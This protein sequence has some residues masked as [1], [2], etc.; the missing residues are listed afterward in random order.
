MKH[1]VAKKTRTFSVETVRPGGKATKQEITIPYPD[2][3]LIVDGQG[4]DGGDGG[5]G[6]NGGKGGK[7]GKGSGDIPGGNG[8]DGG[9]A[10]KGAS[11]GNGGKGA[12]ITISTFSEY[13][14]VLMLMEISADGGQGGV[15]GRDGTIGQGGL[16]G[17]SGEG[18]VLGKTI[19]RLEQI[20]LTCSAHEGGGTATVSGGQNVGLSPITLPGKKGKNGKTG[21]KVKGGGARD[22]EKGPAG[23]I[24]FVVY[25]LCVCVC[26]CARACVCVLCLL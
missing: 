21:K 23:E 5:D 3:T 2:G 26:V 17:D 22:G 14:P 11:G 9:I 7:G 8:G 19:T 4:G 6:G 16:G 12:K 15:R 20:Q 18:L 10:G 13:K 25:G 1:D 24:T